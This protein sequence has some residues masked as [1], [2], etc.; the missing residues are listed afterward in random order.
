MLEDLKAQG[1]EGHIGVSTTVHCRGR[2]MANHRHGVALRQGILQL[3]HNT[4]EV[5]KQLQLAM[6]SMSVYKYKQT[7][8]IPLHM[9]PK[10]RTGC[11]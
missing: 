7:F 10:I 5:T 11:L 4:Q 8:C 3:R 9:A 2:D 6:R 1:G